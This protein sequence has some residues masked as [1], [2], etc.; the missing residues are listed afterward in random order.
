MNAFLNIIFIMSLI[1][2]NIC[3]ATKTTLETKLKESGK[4]KQP[5]TKVINTA[6]NI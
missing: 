4:S 2:L 1:N 5:K 6:L 3:Q